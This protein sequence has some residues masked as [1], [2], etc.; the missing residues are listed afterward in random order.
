MTCLRLFG[1]ISLALGMLCYSSTGYAFSCPDGPVVFEERY[2]RFFFHYSDSSDLDARVGLRVGASNGNETRAFAVVV[3]VSS[4]PNIEGASLPPAKNDVDKLKDFFKAQRFDEI[5]VLEN[6]DAT[7]E[8]INYFLGKYLIERSFLYNGPNG[9]RSRVVVAYSGHGT[10]DVGGAPAALVLSRAQTLSDVNSAYPLSLLRTHLELLAK[11]HFHVL[12]LVNACY[13]G[14]LFGNPLAGG[15]M[16]VSYER[17]AHAV[18]AGA[19]NQLVYSLGNPGE[20]SIFFEKIIEGVTTGKA[21]PNYPTVVDEAGTIQLRGGVVRLGALVDYLQAEIEYLG[22]PRSRTARPK[23]AAP[24]AGPV[25]PPGE[26]ALGG[27]FFLSPEDRPGPKENATVA[28]APPGPVSSIPG[29]PDLKVFNG[30]TEYPIRGVD[31]SSLNGRIDWPVVRKSRQF[32]YVRAT[33]TTSFDELFRRNW[34]ASKSAGMPRGAYHVFSFCQ[35]AAIQFRRIVQQ[36]PNETD[37]LP[38]AIDVEWFEGAA[39]VGPERQCAQRQPERIRG[40]LLSLLK[41]V[42]GE[43]RKRPVIYGG[44]SVFSTLA[45][46]QF[47]NYMVWL[48]AC[49]RSATPEVR[50]AGTIPWTLW[51]YSDRGRVPGISTDVDENAFFGKP[52][53]FEN[54]AMAR[55]NIA[56][57]AVERK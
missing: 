27:F 20:G 5:I 13:G 37:A 28:V 32:A 35:P 34:E 4:Y 24:W 31:V 22:R 42:E 12:A 19:A 8:N 2:C 38:L 51:Q 9:G 48:A 7:E 11:A 21:D 50:L 25:E 46:E 56:L 15:N 23:Y 36:I 10:P 55:G 41:L 29:R 43:Y 26:R 30:P 54:F 47:R 33:G 45:N 1:G 16:S 14:G 3:G 49:G 52:E 39:P 40:E 53:Q 17:G 57:E 44:R 18:T 6:D